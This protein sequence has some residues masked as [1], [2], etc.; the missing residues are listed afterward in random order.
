[1]QKE[2]DRRLLG[3]TSLE[4]FYGVYRNNKFRI[5]D[6]L[7]IPYCYISGYKKISNKGFKKNTKQ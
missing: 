6:K 3:A 1:M 4:I 7:K 2:H 5:S